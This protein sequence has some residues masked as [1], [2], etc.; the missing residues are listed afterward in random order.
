MKE[1]EIQFYDR[2]KFNFELI[3]QQCDALTHVFVSHIMIR[4]ETYIVTTTRQI[5][6]INK[7]KTDT[8]R[9]VEHS[10]QL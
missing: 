9:V 8:I 7:K 6:K 2:L 10:L 1:I 4:I 3:S 5:R